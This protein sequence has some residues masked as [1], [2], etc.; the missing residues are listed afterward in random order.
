MRKMLC[1]RRLFKKLCVKRLCVRRLC[2]RRL[3]VR[4]LRNRRLLCVDYFHVN[5]RA[6]RFQCNIL[7]FCSIKGCFLSFASGMVVLVS[8]KNTPATL[9]DD[10]PGRDA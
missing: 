1:V 4:S 7:S 3:C 6:S 9:V 8:R 2:V 10:L 5:S